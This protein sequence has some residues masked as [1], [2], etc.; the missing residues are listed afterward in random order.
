[1]WLEAAFARLSEVRGVAR[2]SESRGTP[3]ARCLA[4]PALTGHH[5]RPSCAH[6]G[7]GGRSDNYSRR[8]PEDTA[9]YQCVAEHWPEFRERMEQRGGL[10][11]FV[12]EE[13]QAYLNCGRREAGCLELHCRSCGHSLLVALSCKR[14]GVCAACLGRRMSDTAVHLEQEV[15]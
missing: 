9:L 11:K 6:P 15:L 12:E 13:F 5:T 10:P 8:R 7:P 4:V 1:R 14:R 2:T 3:F